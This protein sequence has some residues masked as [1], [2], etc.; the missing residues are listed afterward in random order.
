[1]E[2]NTHN[3]RLLLA[4]L[5]LQATA[6]AYANPLNPT[7]V[8]GQAAFNQQ[9]STLT[10]TNSNNAII[11]WQGFSIG[12]GELTRFNQPSVSSQVLN[13]VTSGLPSEI[14]GSLQSNGHVFL[15]NPSGIAFGANAQVDV[16]GL[17]VSTLNLSNADF[18]A[19]KLNFA[20]QAGAGNI[21]N[22][23][24]LRAS[25]DI[26]LVAPNIQNSGVIQSSNGQI[27]LA[28]GKSVSI[29]DTA[30][31]SISFEVAAPANQALNLGQIVAR[32]IG[33][34]GANITNNGTV[35]A[36]SA[37]VGANGQIMLKAR[38][39]ITTGSVSS[40]SAN[41]A[42]G[43]NITLQATNGLA[44]VQGNVSANGTQGA[45]GNVNV[46][47]TQVHLLDGANV[48]ANGTTGG[49]TVLVGGDAHGANLNV[50]NA[51]NTF[52]ASTAQ[53]H[54]DATQKGNGGKAI[55]WAND[56]TLMYGSVSARGGAQGGN[57]GFVETSAHYLDV[58]GIKVDASAPNGKAGSWLL[59]PINVTITATADA[60]GTFAAGIWTPTLTGSTITNATIQ[61][62]LN[63]GTNVTINTTGALTE[64][65]DITVSAAV[66]KTAGAAATLTLNASNNIAINQPISSTVGALNLVLNHGTAGNATLA[67]S[68]S[69][70][71]GNVDIQKAGVTGAGTL[72][73]TAG[74]TTL[75]GTFA[76]NTLGV[77]G[78][79][80]NLNGTA[81]SAL[82][83]LNLSGGTLSNT[84][85]LNIG[86]LNVNLAGGAG[87]TLGGA[88]AI[89]LSGV[90]GETVTTSVCCW[91]TSTL[92]IDGGKTLTNS[93]ATSARPA[94]AM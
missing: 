29:V 68:L 67:N 3:V 85:V 54:A 12:A 45:G 61:T 46:L 83:T 93:T 51:T 72:N 80:L 42:N 11:N 64:L 49:G 81:A 30:N 32:K 20:A 28:A 66:A 84:G 19:G 7:V 18:L 17:A 22:Q 27:L 53:I 2:H 94:M 69:L 75:T 58:A 59:D 6:S 44:S 50:Q 88:G 24:A 92:T 1:M 90:G 41:G 8:N 37:V 14:L 60:G 33:I 16:A 74:A 73:V 89:N 38:D 47:G 71:G 23:G 5:L 65:G 39:A 86:S 70:L 34:F 9:G 31:P 82:S 52:V 36:D 79:T 43:G 10:V 40:I 4:T 77:S 15:I 35:N 26:I 76:A 25:G 78:G 91:P 48:N 57:G 13:R 87:A 21:N 62:A 63:A 55:V 56:A